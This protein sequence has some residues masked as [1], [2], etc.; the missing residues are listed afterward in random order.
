[1]LSTIS[2]LSNFADGISIGE[3]PV[4]I[5]TFFVSTISS[6]PLAFVIKTFVGSIILA[7]P[8][9]GVTLFVVNKPVIPPVN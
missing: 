7:I 5:I 1:M 8:S 4:A 2:L 9:I 3:E 6:S